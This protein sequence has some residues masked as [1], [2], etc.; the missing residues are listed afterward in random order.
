VDSLSA[1]DYSS[2][3]TTLRAAGVNVRLDPCP[4]AFHS[5]YAV[6]DGAK[7]RLAFLYRAVTGL[8]VHSATMM[9]TSSP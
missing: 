9:K 7:A 3:Y 1:V 4:W 8:P 2:E 6:I 5:K